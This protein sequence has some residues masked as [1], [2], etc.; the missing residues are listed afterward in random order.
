LFILIKAW[1]E[2]GFEKQ[3]R[4]GGVGVPGATWRRFRSFSSV[5]VLSLRVS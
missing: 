3:F 2:A 1:L 4:R 5:I